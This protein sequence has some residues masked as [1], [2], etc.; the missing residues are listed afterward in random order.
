MKISTKRKNKKVK[1]K[2]IN[3][4]NK[5]KEKMEMKNNPIYL[6]ITA[7]AIINRTWCKRIQRMSSHPISTV[8][9]TTITIQWITANRTNK[10]NNHLN[11]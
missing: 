10:H 2:K 7:A 3:E 8:P 9:A 4:N 5:L 11:K 1:S 6:V